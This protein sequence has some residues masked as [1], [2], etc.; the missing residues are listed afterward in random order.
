[1]GRKGGRTSL[2]LTLGAL[3]LEPESGASSVV[4]AALSPPICETGAAAVLLTGLGVE[5]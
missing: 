5:A 3:S 4:Q 2:P 1:M